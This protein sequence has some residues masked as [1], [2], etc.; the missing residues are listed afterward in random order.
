[1]IYHIPITVITGERH[2]Q[3]NNIQNFRVHNH[4]I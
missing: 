3:I 2:T 1:M 4:Y